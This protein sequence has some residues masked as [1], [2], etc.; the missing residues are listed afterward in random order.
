M[1][2][3]NTNLGPIVSQND[4]TTMD[5]ATLAPVRHRQ[6]GTVQGQPTSLALDY[7]GMHVRGQGHTPR[8]GG[9]ARDVTVDTMLAAGT[10]D[11]E[12]LGVLIG[13]LPVA[14]G[15]RWTFAAFDGGENT[16]RTMTVSVSGEESVTTPAGTFACWRVEVNGGQ[17]PVVFSVPKE[18]PYT[19]VKLELVGAPIVFELTGRN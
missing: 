19:H 2:V 13:A 3:T 9:A 6:G 8:P 7:D 12:Q 14:A 10:V 16:V 11:F 4:T 15:G 18:A 17:I 5:A 1:V